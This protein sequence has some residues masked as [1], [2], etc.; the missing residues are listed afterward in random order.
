MGGLCDA[1]L[2]AKR[3]LLDS[4]EIQPRTW[5]DY[6][7][8]RAKIVRAFSRGRL[9]DDLRLDDFRELRARFAKTYGPVACLTT[10][11]EHASCSSSPTD[12]GLIDRP[13]R[14]G[15]GFDKPDKAT[16]RR[17]RNEKG[18]LMFEPEQIRVILDSAIAA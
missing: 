12:D 5:R 15:Q 8:V 13:I 3:Q 6:K 10:S 1:F 11:T 18:E 14:Y 16:L 4:G 7:T 17:A 9:V 2:H